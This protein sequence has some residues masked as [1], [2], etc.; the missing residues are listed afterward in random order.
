[1]RKNSK[2]KPSLAAI[3]RACGVASMTVSRALRQDPRV[4]ED[5]R[6]QILAAA[7]KMGYQPSGRYGRP[8]VSTDKVRTP[9][10]VVLGVSMAAGNLFYS[11][12][13]ISIEQA[14]AQRGCDCV[15]RTG[16]QDYDGF[17]RLCETLRESK[18]VATLLVGF[19]PVMQLQTLLQILPRA[20]LVDHSGDPRLDCPYE[21]VALDNVEAARLA[22]RHLLGLGRRR[23]LLMTGGKDH[24]FSRDIEQG[25]REILQSH[26]LPALPELICRA[27]FTADGARSLLLQIMEHGMSFDAVFSNDEMGVGILR[28]LHEKGKRVPDDVAV[29]GCDGLPVGRHTIP[30][31]TTVELDYRQLGQVAVERALAERPE[32]APPC[33]LRLVPQLVIRESSGGGGGKLEKENER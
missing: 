10:D 6:R 12:L 20:L 15:I 21:F 27:D 7:G 33:R 9:V 5:T 16:N 17:L 23:I 24:Y 13:L 26:D 14:L 30:A 2:R 22:V 32:N 28:A 31:L 11:Q 19:F 18:A 25:W 4:Q 29:A 3:A 8:R 1:M